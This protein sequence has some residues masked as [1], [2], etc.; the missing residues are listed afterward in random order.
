VWDAVRAPSATVKGKIIECDAGD[1]CGLNIEIYS[2][3]GTHAPVYSS[4]SAVGVVIATGNI[5]ETLTENNIGKN[6]YVSRDGGLNW[7]AVKE[8]NYI[9]D[10]GDHGAIILAAKVGEKTK[11]IE[12]TWDFGATWESVQI[13]D[14]EIYITN[15][16]TEPKSVS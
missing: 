7:K 6:L 16:I 4:E 12:F 1:G 2:S 9:Y 14:D 3:A 11:S 8:G 15:I 5:G 10:I 13:T